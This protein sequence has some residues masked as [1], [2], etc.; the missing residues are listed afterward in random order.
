MKKLCLFILLGF[1]FCPTAYTQ[2]TNPLFEQAV[3]CIKEFE[4]WHADEHYPYVGYGHKLLS[5]DNFD[6]EITEEFADSLL[7]ADLM[8][9]CAAFRHFGKDSLLLGVLAY[10]IGEYRLLGYKGQSKSQLI[11]K[12]ERGDRD[13]HYEYITFRKYNGVILE[14]LQ[15]RREAE[16]EILFEE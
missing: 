1:T 11:E 14:S 6:V 10:N 5:T 15:R 16:F 13:I 9:K 3:A 4:G 12:L 8:Q 2:N 7:R